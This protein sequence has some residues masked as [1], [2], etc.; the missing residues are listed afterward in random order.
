M[1][2]VWGLSMSKYCTNGSLTFL[3]TLQYLYYNKLEPICTNRI[4]FATL[5][6][7]IDKGALFEYLLKVSMFETRQNEPVYSPL[8]SMKEK[9]QN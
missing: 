5:S 6:L 7:R 3:K 1:K 8:T 9:F 4:E 2:G